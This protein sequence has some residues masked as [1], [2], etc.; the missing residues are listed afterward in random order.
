MAVFDWAEF[1]EVG[2][3]TWDLRVKFPGGALSPRMHVQTSL[4]ASANS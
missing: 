3:D 1:T 4:Q 2:P